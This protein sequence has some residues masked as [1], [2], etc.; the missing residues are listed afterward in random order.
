MGSDDL[1][2]FDAAAE[3]AHE[4]FRAAGAYEVWDAGRHN[5]HVLG[6]TIMGGSADSSVTN[7]YGQT[8]D[9]PNLFPLFRTTMLGAPDLER[10]AVA[11]VPAAARALPAE[12][13]A[14]Y[15]LGVC[16]TRSSAARSARGASAVHSVQRSTTVEASR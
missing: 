2:C 10:G 12:A 13:R 4:I 14:R 16:A 8:P 1:A 6:G 5:T 15:G 9:L 3:Q 11:A 7:S